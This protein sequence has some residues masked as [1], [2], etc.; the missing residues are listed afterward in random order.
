M[1]NTNMGTRRVNNLVI[2]RHNK[3]DPSD[4]EWD[5]F[6]RAMQ[7]GD[8]VGPARVLV[9]TDGGGPTSDQ[10][11]RLKK[12]VGGVNTRTAIVTDN[13]KARFVVSSIAFISANIKS[14]AKH[15]VDRAYAYLEFEPLQRRTADRHLAELAELVQ[16]S[17]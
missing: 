1:A 8:G 7:A 2:C 14:F 15:E 12:L 9:V 3:N 13:V 5:E 17:L 11:S 6:L 16:A 4:K 10:R